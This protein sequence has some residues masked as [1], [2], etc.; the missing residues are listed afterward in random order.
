MA[1]SDNFEKTLP[2][3]YVLV[4]HVNAANSGKQT[5]VYSLL[6]F[7]PLIIILP[8]LILI[9]YF[10]G[11][12]TQFE[13][14]GAAVIAGC[15]VFI[16]YIILHELTH[17]VTYKCFTGQ[18]LKFGLT[19]TVA[20]CGVPDVYVRKKAS[21]AALIMP[22]A[23]FSVIFLS[24]T[25]GLWF[26]SPLYGIVAGAVFAC[27]LGGCVGDLHWTL[28]YLTKY[29]NCNTLMRDTGPEQWL[30]VPAEEAEKY[31]LPV[32]QTQEQ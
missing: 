6:A 24:L 26:V 16:V 25:V 31:G 3:G 2:K 20:F 1:K 30:Y 21:I 29:K 7:V 28:M 17:G 13:N 9:A 15:A 27:H 11:D 19:L 4:K 14:V 8:L 18:K 12:I 5:L 32:L 22:F 23:V 10:T